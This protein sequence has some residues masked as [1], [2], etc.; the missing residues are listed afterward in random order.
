[1]YNTTLWTALITPMK[2][3]GSVDFE[4]LEK[5]VNE[6]EKAGNG[7]LLIGSTG[8]GLALDGKDKLAVVN[9]VT[10]IKPSVPVMAGVGGFN[11]EIQKSWIEKCNELDVDAFLL[12]TPLYSKPGIKGQIEWFDALLS[13]AQKPCMIYNIPSR[14]GTKLYIDVLRA[15]ENHDN[16]WA[17]KEASGSINEYQD[18][19]NECANVPFFSGDDGLLPFFSVIGC[20][21]L[22]S[23]AANVWPE[24]TNLYTKMCL[25]KKT[26]TIFPVWNRAVKALFSAPNPI[27]AKRLLAHKKWIKTDTVRPPLSSKEIENIEPL[28]RADKEINNWFDE[29]S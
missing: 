3:D 25:Q 24:Q 26:D 4:D 11:L 14:T 29:N 5:L 10:K 19:R 15:I 7:I 16:F 12:V 20:S 13:K 1:M 2:K 9:H 18:F 28:L 8:E 21:G 6:Q 17:V 23:V 27:P 22:V